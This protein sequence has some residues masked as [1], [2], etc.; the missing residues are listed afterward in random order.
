MY[1]KNIYIRIFYLSPDAAQATALMCTN[2]VSYVLL[3][4]ARRGASPATL[5]A[6]VGARQAALLR[7]GRD[8]GYTGEAQ[9]AL[10]AAVSTDMYLT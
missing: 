3:T 4:E 1:Y 5:A 10:R 6:A 2:V 7:D 9:H 8:L